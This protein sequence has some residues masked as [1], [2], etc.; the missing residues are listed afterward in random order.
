LKPSEEI[1]AEI[2]TAAVDAQEAVDRER[3]KLAEIPRN[4]FDRRRVQALRVQ[5]AQVEAQR[6]LDALFSTEPSNS[7]GRP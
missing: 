3:Q 2:H 5:A 1:R 4:D 7:R 6:C